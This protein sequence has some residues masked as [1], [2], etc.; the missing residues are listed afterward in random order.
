MTNFKKK[1]F[2][3]LSGTSVKRL[4]HD[5]AQKLAD[6]DAAKARRKLTNAE[7]TTELWNELQGTWVGN[8]GWNIIAVPSL[9]STPTSEGAFELLIA[10]YIETLTF[11]NAGAL[12]RNRGG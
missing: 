2:K 10:P 7:L 4:S 5:I 1:D 11:T 9:S 6:D 12:A 3:R 8:K